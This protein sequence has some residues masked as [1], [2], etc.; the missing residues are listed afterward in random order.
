MLA[1]LMAAA[2]IKVL[3]GAMSSNDE[4]RATY[5]PFNP[6]IVARSSPLH[7][8]S[9]G[10]WWLVILVLPPRHTLN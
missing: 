6:A 10:R 4:Q 5:R 3:D 9:S 2:A 7:A 1:I 8:T